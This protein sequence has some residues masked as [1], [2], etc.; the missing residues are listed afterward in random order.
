M[1]NENL[2]VADGWPTAVEDARLFPNLELHWVAPHA[3][4]RT[5]SSE[6][7]LGLLDQLPGH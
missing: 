3:I 1:P 4:F 2:V 5:P 6:D 7:R